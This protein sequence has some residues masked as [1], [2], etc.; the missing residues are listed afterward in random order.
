MK[1]ICNDGL[2]IECGNFK[3]IDGGV[4]LTKDKKRKKNNGFVPMA[5]LK[6]IVPDGAVPDDPD[7]ETELSTEVPLPS[8]AQRRE[9]A[10]MR[11][12][13]D[14]LDA[15]AQSS[16]ETDDRPARADEQV[17]GEDDPYPELQ[18]VD[19]LGPTYAGRLYDDGI[20]TLVDLRAA[21]PKEVAA[22]ADV[23]ETRAEDWVTQADE[24]V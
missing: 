6:Y 12:R 2:V 14:R 15:A 24:L 18:R 19:G 4:V 3:A 20:E 17:D 1:V 13:L 23:G 16:R 9:I 7:D 11:S 8:P 22:V 21:D 10:A 5:E